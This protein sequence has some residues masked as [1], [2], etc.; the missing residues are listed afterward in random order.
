MAGINGYP[1][2]LSDIVRGDYRILEVHVSLVDG[3]G[4]PMQTNLQNMEFYL[5]FGDLDTGTAPDL[6]I[7]V[8]AGENLDEAQDMVE[9]HITSIQSASLAAG[10]IY[11]SV[12]M[13]DTTVAGAGKAF[14]LDMGQIAILEAVSSQVG[15]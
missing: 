10:D 9:I 6:E 13:V 15:A 1:G 11:Y 2:A 14:V 8:P 5:T 12:R 7:H 4:N 3:D